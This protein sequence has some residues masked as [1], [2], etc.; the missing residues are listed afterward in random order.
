MSVI[1]ISSGGAEIHKNVTT[2][3]ITMAHTV[4]S[5]NRGIHYYNSYIQ[6]RPIIYSNGITVSLYRSKVVY[7][8]LSLQ[9]SG[10]IGVGIHTLDKGSLERVTQCSISRSIN[11][12]DYKCKA[13]TGTRVVHSKLVF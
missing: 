6:S 8:S 2:D 12:Y 10:P 4:Y 13:I 9:Q 3:V 11:W 7:G 1:E 5:R